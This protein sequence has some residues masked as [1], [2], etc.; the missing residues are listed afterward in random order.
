MPAS[1]QAV[2]LHDG[3]TPTDSSLVQK[4]VANNKIGAIF[5]TSEEYH[6]I[7]TDWD[8]FLNLVAAANSN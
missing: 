8:T 4:L 3:P 1:Q 2:V 5:L 7:P 6:S